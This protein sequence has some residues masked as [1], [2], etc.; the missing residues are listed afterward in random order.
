[1]ANNWWSA[2]TSAIN[3]GD[4]WIMDIGGRVNG[5][6]PMAKAMFGVSVVR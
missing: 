5:K 6:R 4:A 1:V 2:T 3:T